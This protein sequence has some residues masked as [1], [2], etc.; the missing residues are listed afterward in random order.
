MPYAK[1][2]TAVSK[3]LRPKARPMDKTPRAEKGDATLMRMANKNKKKQK[4]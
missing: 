2:T 1:K 3:S 4:K